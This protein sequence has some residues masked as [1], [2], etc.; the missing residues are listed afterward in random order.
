TRP[1]SSRLGGAG[2]ATSYTKDFLARGR[3]ARSP[4]LLPLYHLLPIPLFSLLSI[5]P[6]VARAVTT[7]L[8]LTT[9]LILFSIFTE[10]PVWYRYLIDWIGSPS[11]IQIGSRL[12]CI[13]S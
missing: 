5:T 3:N 2:R 4:L 8:T 6:L 10:L 13:S 11:R 9:S 1:S 7:S 12:R